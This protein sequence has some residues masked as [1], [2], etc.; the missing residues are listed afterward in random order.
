LDDGAVVPLLPLL[1]L[2]SSP[3]VGDGASLSGP[4]VSFVV[5]ALLLDA[6]EPL[7]EPVVTAAEAAPWPAS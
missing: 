4:P 2:S 6:F 3:L 1:P 5:G 7:F